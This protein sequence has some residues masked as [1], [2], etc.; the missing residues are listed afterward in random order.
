MVHI[1]ASSDE[2][3]HAMRGMREM[4]LILSNF[5]VKDKRDDRVVLTE[6]ICFFSSRRLHTRYWRDWSSDVALPILGP[7]S[8][9]ARDLQRRSGGWGIS[10]ARRSRPQW[11]NRGAAADSSALFCRLPP[12]PGIHSA[13]KRP[14]R[15]EER[16]VGKECR[17][18][19][20]PYH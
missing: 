6:F 3:I 13:D 4:N 9:P 8:A 16:R 7:A 5:V 1:Q 10:P 20:S 2:M 14:T 12:P 11:E 19:W 15:S 17:S 18:R